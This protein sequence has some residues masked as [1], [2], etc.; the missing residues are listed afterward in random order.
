MKLIICYIYIY[1][2]SQNLCETSVIYK[3]TDLSEKLYIY[4][5]IMS[6]LNSLRW[7]AGQRNSYSA[8]HKRT[9]F[10]R[11]CFS[12]S[13]FIYGFSRDVSLEVSAFVLLLNLVLIN[14]PF[15]ASVLRTQYFTWCRSW[16]IF[17]YYKF[18]PFCLQHYLEFKYQR[19]WNINWRL[20]DDRSF[21]LSVIVNIFRLN[22]PTYTQITC[23]ST[24]M[25]LQ[26]GSQMD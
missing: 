21:F 24:R 12:R 23:T 18:K 3:F 26:L 6:V 17:G 5:Y 2:V 10:E 13:K 20:V 25:L 16:C 14:P 8:A 22:I 11:L 19:H 1:N 4:I 7:F 9:L 15:P